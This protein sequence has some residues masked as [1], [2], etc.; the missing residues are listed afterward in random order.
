VSDSASTSPYYLA[1]DDLSERECC[2][3]TPEPDEAALEQARGSLRRLAVAL[4]LAIVLAFLCWVLAPRW[5]VHLPMIVPLMGFVAI[6]V[7]T[8]MAAAEAR[9]KG[10]SQCDE[11]PGRPMCCAGPRPVGER[12][13][14]LSDKH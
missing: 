13:R 10:K 3:E 8:I 12:L 7:G 1:E 5:G 14:M 6:A 11:T 4:G 2:L 9:P